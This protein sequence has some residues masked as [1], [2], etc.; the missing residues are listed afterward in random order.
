V[1]EQ[2]EA[3]AL[4]IWA[5][6]E[7]LD[8]SERFRAVAGS[9]S[10]S[11][12]QD[13]FKRHVDYLV[14]GLL[15]EIDGAPYAADLLLLD[16]EL[17]LNVA[18]WTELAHKH[19][20]PK[21]QLRFS[22][23]DPP[24]PEAG[25]AVYC[26]WNYIRKQRRVAV[27]APELTNLKASADIVV[28]EESEDPDRRPAWDPRRVEKMFKPCRD[29][30]AFRSLLCVPVAAM[31]PQAE[32]TD[33]EQEFQC[34]GALCLT[35]SVPLEFTQI[36][37]EWAWTCGVLIG[38]MFTTYFARWKELTGDELTE[39]HLAKTFSPSVSSLPG[40]DEEGGGRFTEPPSTGNRRSRPIT[41]GQHPREQKRRP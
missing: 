26:L 12:L 7:A 22:G 13:E 6:R 24:E 3:A 10:G 1:S 36:D 29:R 39:G 8:W 35:R 16:E 2:S 19:A 33:E 27:I 31:M 17:R 23:D 11:A 9:L 4:R 18:V 41:T 37:I 21:M 38:A 25:A 5:L 20:T 15:I 28:Y 34:V 14:D 40:T 30:A 32:H